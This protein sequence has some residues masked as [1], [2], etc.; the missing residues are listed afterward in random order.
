MEELDPGL[1]AAEK[2]QHPVKDEEAAREKIILLQEKSIQRL[3]LLAQSLR[4]QLLQC[5]AA[6]GS[7]P[8]AAAGDPLA[9]RP[10]Q[11]EEDGVPQEIL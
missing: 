6:N 10:S 1:G 9:K 5:R 11:I 2:Q 3:T 8:D 4:Q 7:G